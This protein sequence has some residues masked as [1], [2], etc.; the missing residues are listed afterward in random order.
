MPLP[1][2][3]RPSIP[4]IGHVNNKK[5]ETQ[6][7]TRREHNGAAEKC[8][9]SSHPP[10][11]LRRGPQGNSNDARRR[12]RVAACGARTG[13][14]SPQTHR[15][16]AV[17]AARRP[18]IPRLHC[19]LSRGAR[20]AR[21]ERAS[22]HPD[23]LSLGSARRTIARAIR[24]GTGG[25]ATPCYCDPE[26]AHHRGGAATDPQHPDCFCRRIRSRRQRF[27]RRPAAPWGQRDRLHRSRR[28]AR[29]QMAGASQGDRANH[30]PHGFPVQSGDGAVRRIL[31]QAVQSRRSLLGS[32]S[33]FSPGK[34]RIRAGSPYCHPSTRAQ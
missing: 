12:S 32:R 5:Y 15:G 16:P 24:E 31:P 29:R 18:R 2:A 13:R 9:R 19:R 6:R 30:G 1:V 8:C 26:H 10:S 34:G 27:C 11:P 20:D 21:L 14:G 7:S 4:A 22:Q 33:N 23:R 25:A 28:L 3:N 17:G